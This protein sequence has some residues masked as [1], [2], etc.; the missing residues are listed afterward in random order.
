MKWLPGTVVRSVGAKSFEVKLASGVL[1]RRHQTGSVVVLLDLTS[2]LAISHVVII[3]H[4]LTL[5]L[6]SLY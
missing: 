5:L 3:L 6:I 4:I 1:V 2:D